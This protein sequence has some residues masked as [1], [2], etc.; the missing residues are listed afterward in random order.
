MTIPRPHDRPITHAAADEAI[1]TFTVRLP[2]A[3]VHTPPSSTGRREHPSAPQLKSVQCEPPNLAGVRVLVVDD[4]SDAREVIKRVLEECSAEVVL[5]ASAME[6]F[7]A[8]GRVKPDVI[9]ID[10]GMPGLRGDHLA[11]LMFSEQRLSG[12]SLVLHSSLPEPQLAKL[13]KECG[14]T[15]YIVKSSSS[16]QFLRD[17]HAL[18]SQRPARPQTR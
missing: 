11:R 6:A 8:A 17:F 5:A 10:I 16:A 13:T 2:F 12:T 9:L 18:L 4:E 3:V 1:E 14:A 15:G 7:A